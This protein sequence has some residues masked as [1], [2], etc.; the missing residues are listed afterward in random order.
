M[1]GDGEKPESSAKLAEDEEMLGKLK[2]EQSGA[3]SAFTR[4]ANILTRTANSSTEG[5]LKA[6]WDKFGSEYCNLISANT[7]YIEALSKADTEASRQ[8]ADNVGKMAEDCDQWFAEVEQEVMS[9]LWSRLAELELAP[10]ARR[11]EKAMD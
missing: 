10:L 6:E 1:T 4:R 2:R 8:Q 11:A 7:V 3:Q 5:N 9:V